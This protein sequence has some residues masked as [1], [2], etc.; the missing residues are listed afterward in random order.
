MRSDHGVVFCFVGGGSEWRKI[1]RKSRKQKAESRNRI[2]R[3]I[4]EGANFSVSA[5]QR[6]SFSNLLCLPYQPLDQLAGSLSAADLHVVVMGDAFVGLVHP[7]KIYNILSVAAPVLYIGPRPSHLSEMLDGLNQEYPCASVAHGEVER[8][9]QEIQR[10]RRQP[11]LVA[12]P[13]VRSCARKVFQ[14]GPSAQAHGGV[15]GERKRTTG[16]RDHRTTD[17]RTLAIHTSP[18]GHMPG[19]SW[20]YFI[21]FSFSAFQLFSFCFSEWSAVQL[22][23]FTACSPQWS[24]HVVF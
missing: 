5:F 17:N 18:A 4:S 10:L 23:Q 11:G 3:G 20:T 6:F 2:A 22:S 19:A 15:G 1:S 7:C 14:G 8:V 12:R 24:F 21:L 13:D 16:L 9:V